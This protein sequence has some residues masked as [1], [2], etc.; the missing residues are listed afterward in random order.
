MS[1]G[2]DAPDEHEQALRAA[3][4]TGIER[5]GKNLDAFR[6]RDAATEAMNVARAANK[7]FNDKAPWKSIKEESGRCGAHHER[8]SSDDPNPVDSLRTTH[9]ACQ[10]LDAEDARRGGH[11]RC[12]RPSDRFGPV[13][14]SG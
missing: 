6:F 11:H 13:V 12:T 5:V 10:C 4:S 7:Y 2:A 8:V 9:A 1:N 14:H 3:I